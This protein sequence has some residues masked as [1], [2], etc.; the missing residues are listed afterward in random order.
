MLIVL[1]RALYEVMK[2]I[3]IR[4]EMIIENFHKTNTFHQKQSVDT[5]FLLLLCILYP[6]PYLINIQL[7]KINFEILLNK[8]PVDLLYCCTLSTPYP[9]ISNVIKFHFRIQF[10]ELMK[11]VVK[12]NKNKQQKKKITWK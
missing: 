7:Y 10:D 1:F 2:R 4:Q 6:L 12:D 9:Q 5:F 11:H 8:L 3:E